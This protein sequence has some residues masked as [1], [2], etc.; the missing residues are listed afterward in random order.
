MHRGHT[1]HDYP[2]PWHDY[3]I[4]CI[5]LYMTSQARILKL[6]VHFRPI[7]KEIGNSMYN[8][9]IFVSH[10]I[11]YLRQA[12]SQHEGTTT[13]QSPSRI[14]HLIITADCVMITVGANCLSL[15]TIVS[16]LAHEI[17]FLHRLY[18]RI[19]TQGSRSNSREI[20]VAALFIRS[21]NYKCCRRNLVDRTR[22]GR[23]KRE[24]DFKLERE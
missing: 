22:Q 3:W 13:R 7:R 15:A 6:T 4:I 21:N 12:E 19:A 9:T 11:C 8:N 17:D 2:W 16:Q 20:R 23:R 18:S 24:F 10:D 14:D 1:R 5:V